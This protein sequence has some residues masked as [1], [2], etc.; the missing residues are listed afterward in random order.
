MEGMKRIGVAAFFLA[1][2]A[3]VVALAHTADGQAA[4]ST[5]FLPVVSRDGTGP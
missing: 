3:S 2:A 5:L 4:S 1:V